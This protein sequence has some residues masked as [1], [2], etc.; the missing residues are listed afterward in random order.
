MC[1][2]QEVSV[3]L[4]KL[5]RKLKK[6]FVKVRSK[7]YEQQNICL[8]ILNLNSEGWKKVSVPRK[9]SLR[10]KISFIHI[11]NMRARHPSLLET[12]N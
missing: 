6:R 11:A 12:M 8:E 1:L 3:H 10:A 7:V 4:K 2:L 9:H 5:L